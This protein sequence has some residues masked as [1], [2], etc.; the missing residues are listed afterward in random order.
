MVCVA[1]LPAGADLFEATAAASKRNPAVR[2]VPVR[3]LGNCSRSLS[4]AI[5]KA[6]SWTYVYGDLDAT[7]DGPELIRGALLLG[8]TEDGLMPWKGRPEALKKGLIARVPPPELVDQPAVTPQ[9][10]LG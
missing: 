9:R 7:K 5:S 8:D 3:C 2:V 4:A 1:C 10:E 6:N